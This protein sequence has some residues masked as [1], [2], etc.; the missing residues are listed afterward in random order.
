MT[1]KIMALMATSELTRDQLRGLTGDQLSWLTSRDQLRGLTRDQLSWLTGDQLSWLTRDQLRGLTRDQLRGLTRDQLSWLTG[2]QMSWLT[3]DQLSWLTRDQLR[4]LTRDQLRGLTRDQKIPKVKSLYSAMLADIQKSARLLDQKTFGPDNGPAE[5]NV[6]KTPMCIA[7][8]T[9]SLA[10]TAGYDLCKRLGFAGAA[11][12]I[13]RMSRPDAPLPR[14]D[15]YP[16][17]WALAYIEAR[18]AEES[19]S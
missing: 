6:C 8:H 17:E 13:H 3:R 18:A 19:Q 14:Y 11:T 15:S 7:G 1:K 16:N 9:V 5:D 2:D 12:L 10:G 4:G